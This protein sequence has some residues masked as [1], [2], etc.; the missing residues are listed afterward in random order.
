[1]ITSNVIAN[2]D[3]LSNYRVLNRNVSTNSGVPPNLTRR[4]STP[5]A[6]F[7]IRTY[8]A[9]VEIGFAAYDAL[10]RQVNVLRQDSRPEK[11]EKKKKDEKEKERKQTMLTDTMTTKTRSLMS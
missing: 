6:Y 11:K 5:L 1:M 2:N 9:A 10:V 3:V 7:D 8:E 4:D